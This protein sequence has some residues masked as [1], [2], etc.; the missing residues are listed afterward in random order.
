MFVSSVLA[1]GL[2]QRSTGAVSSAGVV[3]V[4]TNLAYENG[5]AAGTGMVLSSSGLVLTNNH[6]I[7]GATSIRVDVPGTGRSYAA[8]V[9]G[10]SVTADV[11][12]LQLKGSSGLRAVRLGNSSRLKVGAR[13]TALGNARGAGGAPATSSGKVTG[14]NRSIDVSDGVGLTARLTGLIRV[15]ASLEPGDSGGPLFD[16]AGRVIGMDTAASVGFNFV[17]TH[18]GYAIPINRAVALAK[19]IR[20]GRA[21]AIVHVGSTPFLGVSVG[22]SG[23]GVVGAYVLRVA[24]GSPADRAGIVAG[25]TITTVDGRRI[26]SY[27]A[28]TLA[29]LRHHAGETVTVG[30]VDES[31][32]T[33]KTRVKTV[34]GPPQ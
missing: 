27:T 11:A 12:L 31:G 33:G 29:L 28:L 1:L 5:A 14:L 9:L 2:A 20:R 22:A 24:S 17:S 15:D 23:G 32:N 26:V 4:T 18:E 6:V 34:A 16:A 10:Y 30:W 13:V 3:D 21:S 8:S 19:Q 25:D 7:R